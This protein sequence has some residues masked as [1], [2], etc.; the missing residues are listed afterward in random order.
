[1]GGVE[2]CLAVRGGE[3]W[4]RAGSHQELDQVGIAELD[5][6]DERR[7]SSDA[8]RRSKLS[9][10]A[11]DDGRP[12]LRTGHRHSAASGERRRIRHCVYFGAGL[13]EHLYGRSITPPCCDEEGR[14][15]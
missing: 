12:S 9:A 4:V 6:L 10:R 1:M 5:G 2:G 7:A 3:V 14:G 8:L 11:S 15:P 13:D